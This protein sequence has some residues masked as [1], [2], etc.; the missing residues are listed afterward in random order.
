MNPR[1]V[2]YGRRCLQAADLEDLAPSLVL[3]QALKVGSVITTASSFANQ[4]NYYEQFGRCTRSYHE[5]G[6]GIQGTVYERRGDKHVTKE[7]LPTNQGRRLFE[8]FEMHGLVK[9]NFDR[10]GPLAGCNVRVPEVYESIQGMY[11]KAYFLPG[12][13]ENVRHL[14]KIMEM[15]RI[16]PLPKVVRKALIEIFY[17]DRADARDEHVVTRILS[18]RA[19]KHCLARVY[20][21][22]ETVA[23]S[24]ES[25]TLRNFPLTI[26]SM[27][28][29]GLDVESFAKM[30][31]SAYAVLHW[32]AR[33]TVDDVEFVLGTSTTTTDG[34]IH[35]REVDMYLLDFGQCARVYLFKQDKKDVFQA[36]KEAMVLPRNQMYLPHPRR[37]PKLYGIWKSYYL[38]SSQIMISL[39]D[40]PFDPHTLIE[41]YEKCLKEIDP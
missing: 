32:G 20:L 31:G 1:N 28:D 16:L 39:K 14:R 5:I 26:K 15:D 19:N 17:P 33:M 25:F 3:Q 12:F 11:T 8:E 24:K 6:S 22:K 35:G 37:N 10:Y 40:L 30:I 2:L 38:H 27:C 7:E 29:L 21:G 36:F 13:P 4:L 34:G 41:E 18:E 23:M 9:D